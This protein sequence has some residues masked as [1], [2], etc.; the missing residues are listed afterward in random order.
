MSK[1]K[2]KAVKSNDIMGLSNDVM[3]FMQHLG[4]KN[5]WIIQAE[6]W[7][8]DVYILSTKY[9]FSYCAKNEFAF[10]L[11]KVYDIETDIMG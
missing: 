9:H 4:R 8:S 7:W 1:K 11:K 2:E 5:F 3:A 10:W 6:K